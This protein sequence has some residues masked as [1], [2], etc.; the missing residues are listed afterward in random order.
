MG[1]G[2]GQQVRDF[3][4]QHVVDKAIIKRWVTLFNYLSP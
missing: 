2:G 4:L 1:P 3:E